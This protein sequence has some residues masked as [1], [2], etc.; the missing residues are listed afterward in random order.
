MYARHCCSGNFF[1]GVRGQ[2]TLAQKGL[3][4][5]I[6]DDLSVSQL[7]GVFVGPS[8][9]F[10]GVRHCSLALARP[11]EL[12]AGGVWQFL[13]SGVRVNTHRRDCRKTVNLHSRHKGIRV[14][15]YPHKT[16]VHTRAET[17]QVVG[18]I[19]KIIA[20]YDLFDFIIIVQV[21][22]E[23]VWLVKIAPKFPHSC[24]SGSCRRHLL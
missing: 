18:K 13:K 1:C 24:T 19:T 10:A 21:R 9:T 12:A 20:L 8:P 11:T 3:N 4:S 7:A 15:L 5:R 16:P 17:H 2:A 14:G 23:P 6:P 22:D